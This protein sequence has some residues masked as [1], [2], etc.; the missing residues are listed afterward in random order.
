METHTEGTKLESHRGVTLN[1]DP[2]RGYNLWGL[3]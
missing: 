1:G 2:Y 3:I